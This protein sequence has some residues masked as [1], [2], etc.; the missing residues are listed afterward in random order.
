MNVHTYVIEETFFGNIKKNRYLL[1]LHEKQH[2]NEDTFNINLR[3]WTEIIDNPYIIWK[4]TYLLQYMWV[5][6][7]VVV[8]SFPEIEKK[9]VSIISDSTLQPIY[10]N[11]G[12]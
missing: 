9:D 7:D 1:N 4:N 2:E 11:F 8:S 12:N 6:W 10:Y 5:H 3:K